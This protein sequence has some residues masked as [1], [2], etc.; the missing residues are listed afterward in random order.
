MNKDLNAIL[1]IRE[2][3]D[4]IDQDELVNLLGKCNFSLVEGR[5][6]TSFR[7]TDGV[8]KTIYAINGPIES[9]E[10]LKEEIQK[11]EYRVY[12]NLKGESIGGFGTPGPTQ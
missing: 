12:A 5:K 6:P 4:K 1:E 2:A 11:K 8:T 7:D 3:P 10:L 9:Y